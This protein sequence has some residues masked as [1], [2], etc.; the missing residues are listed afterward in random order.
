LNGTVRAHGAPRAALTPEVLE[1]TYGAPM[2]V[3]EHGGMP[4]V[5]DVDPA[6]ARLRAV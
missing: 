3:L 1:A 6:A 4:V 5:V 2:E